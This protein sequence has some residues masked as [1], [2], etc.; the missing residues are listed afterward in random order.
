MKLTI[1]EIH[2][3]LLAAAAHCDDD[4]K[5]ADLRESMNVSV[6]HAI[7]RG[8]CHLPG[9]VCELA[10]TFDEVVSSARQAR[11]EAAAAARPK[12]AAAPKRPA[13]SKPEGAE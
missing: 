4:E 10:L 12:P 7:A 11:R 13:K 8:V 2:N 3:T 1:H 9:K 6:L 5:L